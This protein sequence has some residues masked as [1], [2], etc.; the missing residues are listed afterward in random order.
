MNQSK[1]D[2]QSIVRTNIY[3]RYRNFQKTSS[4]YTKLFKTSKRMCQ[5]FTNNMK[6]AME[7]KNL[8]MIQSKRFPLKK[9][10]LLRM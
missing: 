8:S 5:L 2:L 10:H 4:V 9:R 6:I 1:K 3:T 7:R